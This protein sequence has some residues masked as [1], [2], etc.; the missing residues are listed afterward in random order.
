VF[1]TAVNRQLSSARRRGVELV[2]RIR[3][4]TPG[5]TGATWTGHSVVMIHGGHGTASSKLANAIL[6][7]A[8]PAT[9]Q[10]VKAILSKSLEVLVLTMFFCCKC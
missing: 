9:G 10:V 5:A 7:P 6:R 4:R 2:Q 8:T 3:V 1:A